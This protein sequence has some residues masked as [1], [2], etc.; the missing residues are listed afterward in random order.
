MELVLLVEV[1][2]VKVLVVEVVLLVVCTVEQYNNVVQLV[3]A[4]VGGVTTAEL[5]NR[6]TESQPVSEAE[7]PL[8]TPPLSCPE[9]L[10]V[11]VVVVVV[12][13]FVTTETCHT[14]TSS[15]LSTD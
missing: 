8:Q 14:T 6:R 12:V 15:I 10:R 2:V 1:L 5:L 4:G 13:I 9:A 7:A 3:E 11:V